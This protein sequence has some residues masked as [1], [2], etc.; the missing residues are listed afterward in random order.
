MAA[1]WFKSFT[2]PAEGWFVL[3]WGLMSLAGLYVLMQH[4]K[5][6]IAAI[7]ENWLGKGQLFYLV[8]LWI[9]VIANFERALP[10]FTAQR[11]LTEGTIFVNAIL[12]SVMVLL[13]PVRLA[14]EP[15]TR[16]R[17]SWGP[18]FGW[19]AA[20]L[21]AALLVAGALMPAAVRGVYGDAHAGH[22][23]AN[24]RFGEKANWR[25]T[26]LEKGKRHL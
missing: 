14:V 13:W 8:L 10:A 15:P 12:A 24:Y 26:P 11:I 3:M 19:A 5:R 16:G 4:R 9:M 21:A 17:D 7:P 20:G 22:S 2:L 25:V 6:P 18:E 23:G 1:P